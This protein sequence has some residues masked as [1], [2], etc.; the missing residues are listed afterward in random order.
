MEF[1]SSL[2]RAGHALVHAFTPNQEAIKQYGVKGW[3][4]RKI[5][6][7]AFADRLIRTRKV[8]VVE[9]H[10]LPSLK[11]N[12]KPK[13]VETSHLFN[14]KQLTVIKKAANGFMDRVLD[15]YPDE[16]PSKYGHALCITESIFKLIETIDSCCKDF[17]ITDEQMDQV[18]Q[19]QVKKAMSQLKAKD[20]KKILSHLSGSSLAGAVISARIL[21][22]EHPDD[23]K[24]KV[25]LKVADAACTGILDHK[26]ARKEASDIQKRLRHENHVSK[27]GIPS[28]PA[29]LV[30]SIDT[31]ISERNL[32]LSESR[33][34]SLFVEEQQPPIPA[35]ASAAI[36]KFKQEGPPSRE[37][38]KSLVSNYLKA[39]KENDRDGMIAGM[40]CLHKGVLDNMW[41]GKS[42]TPLSEDPTE[43]SVAG[44]DDIPGQLKPVIEEVLGS[45]S[46]TE[47]S[48]LKEASKK[49]DL[50]KVAASMDLYM[51]WFSSKSDILSKQTPNVLVTCIPPF[52]EFASQLGIVDDI[53]AF[54]AEAN[55]IVEATYDG[56]SSVSALTFQEVHQTAQ[57]I[58]ELDSQLFGGKD[59]NS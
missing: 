26:S 48:E 29:A 43:W 18:V 35:R 46:E 10:E 15:R 21:S 9:S 13:T 49:A 34:P 8:R 27:R 51:N 7:K 14:N 19:Q 58:E 12:D 54:S 30:N 45:L 55:E 39:I 40:F 56:K 41:Q 42:A 17:P 36:A 4:V 24:L 52:S 33:L 31:H 37:Q 16:Q 53:A 1:P 38:L 47:L 32:D 25:F 28:V 2:I 3:L 23:E 59:T 44:A 20:Q 11:R 50:T 22:R 5:L 6:P 57:M